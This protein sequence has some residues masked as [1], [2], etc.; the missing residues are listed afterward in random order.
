M[1]TLLFAAAELVAGLICYVGWMLVAN[2]WRALPRATRNLWGP[3]LD[4]VGVAV[5]LGA[6]VIVVVFL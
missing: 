1:S 5:V 6:V 4:A 2:W 3:V